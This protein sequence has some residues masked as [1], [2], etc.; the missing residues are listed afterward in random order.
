MS[1]HAMVLVDKPDTPAVQLAPLPVFLGQVMVEA[2][3]AYKDLQGALDRAMPDQLMDISGR[4]FRKKGYWRA[5]AVAFNLDVKLELERVEVS[6]Q[7]LDGRDNFTYLV[8]YRATAP[9]GRT[10]T[11]DGAAS[12]MEKAGKFKCPHQKKGARKGY[13]EHWPPDT[14]PDFDP[15]H[16][17]K[18]L[19][20]EATIHNVR[21]HAH[22]RAFNR[23]V[24]NLVGFGEVSAEEIERDHERETSHHEY[25]VTPPPVQIALPDGAYQVMRVVA[26]RAKTDSGA[27]IEWSDVTVRNA[28]HEEQT[29]P[30]PSDAIGAASSTLEQLAQEAV[31]VWL[32]FAEITRGPNKGQKKLVAAHRQPP[33]AKDDNAAL[34]AEILAAEESPVGF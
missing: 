8:T 22:T 5:I 24:S 13:A 29:L 27:V 7:F 25:E 20:Q 26:R 17:W 30:S 23:A 4:K 10:I 15:D 1:G 2:L 12:A 11:G 32:E 3:S 14:C 19:P 6:G 34:D 18:R 16:A 33:V 28:K 21:S 31:P 9:N